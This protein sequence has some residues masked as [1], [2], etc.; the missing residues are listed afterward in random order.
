MFS[1]LKGKLLAIGGVIIAILLGLVKFL[2][3]RNNSLKQEVKSA[4]KQLQFKEK[5]DIIEEEIEQEYSHRAEEARRDLDEGNI[6]EH[7]RNPRD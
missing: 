7:L 5:V 1:F 2:T 6:P 3:Y 4:K